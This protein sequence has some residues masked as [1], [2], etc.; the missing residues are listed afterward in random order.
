[1]YEEKNTGKKCINHVGILLLNVILCGIQDEVCSNG[2]GET[3]EEEEEGD[4]EEEV[5]CVELVE[6]D[7]P[8]DEVQCSMSKKFRTPTTEASASSSTTTSTDSASET[9]VAA[10]PA[11]NVAGRCCVCFSFIVPS[12]WT[13]LLMVKDR[14]LLVVCSF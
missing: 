5:G 2:G 13:A 14:I 3:E 9:A 8:D 11:L 6:A 1:M 12:K 10:L 4:E 7:S